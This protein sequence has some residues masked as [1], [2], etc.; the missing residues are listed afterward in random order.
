MLKASALYIVIVISLVIGILCSS[1]IVTAYYY[2]AEYQKKFRYDQLKNNLSSGINI[3]LAGADSSYTNEKTF[4]LFDREN[5]SVS[6]QRITWGIYDIG[7][8][9]AF[10]QQ[11]TLYKTFTI[12]SK[13]D[14]TKWSALY[15][16]DEDRPV[17]VSGTTMIRGDAYLPKT[18]IQ[19]AYVNNTA[20]KGDKRLVIGK[21]MVSDKYLPSLDTS[22]LRGLSQYFTAKGDSVFTQDSVQHSFLLPVK[23]L[24]FK[25]EAQIISDVKL[26][27][28]IVLHSD[29]TITIDSTAK[30]DG[31]LVFARVIVVNDGFR[32]K[33]QLFATDSISIGKSC[34][35]E[36][37][38]CL[39]VIRFTK[40]PIPS[41]AKISLGD[42]SNFN[43]LIFNYEK[44]PGAA[45]PLISI[46]KADTLKGQIYSQNTLELKDKVRIDGSIVTGS[47]LYRSAFTLYQNYLIN[48]TLDSKSLSSYYLASPILPA[49]SKKKKI[50]QW[51][52]Q[53]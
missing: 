18:G 17:S 29:T 31:I 11:D 10:I 1:L 7:V 23:V 40:P 24:D 3:L 13:I 47:F 28:N 36:Y 41:L 45:K 4:S 12:A 9:K 44:E 27:G 43:G 48:A 52:E 30:M 35:F 25:K 19:Q 53:N 26:K 37:P 46:G 16:V 32:G 49:S 14:S 2:R 20:Y 39:G 33:C 5:D 15:L 50:L 22:R 51:L 42:N 38:S 34:H 21:K 6:L 8:A